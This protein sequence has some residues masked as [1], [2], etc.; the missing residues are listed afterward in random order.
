ML[1]IRGASGVGHRKRR[2]NERALSLTA[3]RAWVQRTWVRAL[4]R[5]ELLAT[6]SLVRIGWAQGRFSVLDWVWLLPWGEWVLEGLSV[7]WPWLGRQAE[8]RVLH[9]AVARFRWASML[10]CS[11][12]VIAHWLAPNEG[13]GAG[14]RVLA[15]IGFLSEEIVWHTE[16]EGEEEPITWIAVKHVSDG[17]QVWFGNLFYLTVQEE[18]VFQLRQTILM[19]RRL[20]GVQ[21]RRGSRATREG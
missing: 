20:E 8:M 19:L 16:S 9:W 14:S 2:E 1:D 11:A 4:A 12:Q 5:S 13:I 6:L 21:S 3:G 15:G 10:I 7:V 18:E 17:W